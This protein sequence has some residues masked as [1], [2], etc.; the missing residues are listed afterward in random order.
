M[1]FCDVN[2]STWPFQVTTMK[3][4]GPEYFR[5]WWDKS[6]FENKLSKCKI[7]MLENHLYAHDYALGCQ[8]CAMNLSACCLESCSTTLFLLFASESSH[9]PSNPTRWKMLSQWGTNQMQ[10][11]VECWGFGY[12]AWLEPEKRAPVGRAQSTRRIRRA[13]CQGKGKRWA[14]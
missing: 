9:M 5:V 1:I 11:S 4:N 14:W 7:R 3:T 12:C 2:T 6:L 8:N 10:V 13:R